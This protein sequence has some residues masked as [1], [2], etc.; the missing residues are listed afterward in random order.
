M[1]PDQL[2][3]Q[4]MNPPPTTYVPTFINAYT[5]SRAELETYAHDPKN[6]VPIPDPYVKVEM[7]RRV[8]AHM[9]QNKDANKGANKDANKGGVKKRTL[10]KKRKMNE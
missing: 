9:D 1:S 5:M 3:D 4:I 2:Y 7:Q 10:K 8:Q 6:R